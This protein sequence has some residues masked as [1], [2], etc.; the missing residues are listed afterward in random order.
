[1]EYLLFTVFAALCLALLVVILKW[2]TEVAQWRAGYAE[3]L[4]T[5]LDNE[6]RAAEKHKKE[7]DEVYQLVKEI[8]KDAEDAGEVAEAMAERKMKMET[9]HQIKVRGLENALDI[10]SDAHRREIKRNRGLKALLEI[11]RG[12]KQ[13]LAVLLKR[14]N[15]ERLTYT[16]DRYGV[17]AHF[18]LNT[19]GTVV[20]KALERGKVS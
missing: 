9:R 4:E 15:P 2:K 16:H 13:H 14:L 11:E 5:S 10:V 19:V 18:R 17:Q 7:M 20:N 6:V 12:E 8:R 1:M 3:A